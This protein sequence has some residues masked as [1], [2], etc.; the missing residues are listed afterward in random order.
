MTN[1]DQKVV[2]QGKSRNEFLCNKYKKELDLFDEGLTFD[3]NSFEYY[4][5]GKNF[6]KE[7]L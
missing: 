5:T 6:V 1:E 2:L 4:E 3:S 7:L